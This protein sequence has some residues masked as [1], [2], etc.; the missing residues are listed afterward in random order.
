MT[1]PPWY[2]GAEIGT[3]PMMTT[4][5]SSC[6]LIKLKAL[7]RGTV[8][9]LRRGRIVANYIPALM[10]TYSRKSSKEGPSVKRDGNDEGGISSLNKCSAMPLCIE[11]QLLVILIHPHIIYNY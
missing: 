7:Y 3:T 10:G 2:G 4:G 6:Y 1:T 9:T 11:L 5:S 8:L